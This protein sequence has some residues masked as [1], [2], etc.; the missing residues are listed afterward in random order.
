MKKFVTVGLVMSC[1]L[2]PASVYAAAAGSTALTES[3]GAADNTAAAF[4]LE[5]SATEVRRGGGIAISGTA[6][7]GMQDVVLKI[8]SPNQTV[9]YV[10]V[11]T[12]A[13]GSYSVN[14]AIPTSEELAPLGTYTVVAGSGGVQA[15]K[16][17]AVAGDGNNPGNGG[18]D[19]DNGG[20]NPGN[21]GNDPDNGGGNPGNGGGSGGGSGS[22]GGGGGTVV[23]PPK[24]TGI[25]SGAGQA[26]AAVIQPEQGQN[27]SYIVGA[28]T[29]AE[30]AGQAKDAVTIQ[31]PATAGESGAPLE[32]P[33][34]ALKDLQSKR[35]DLIITSG[36]HTV[37]F[38]AGSIGVSSTK[39][40]SILRFV[41]NTVMTEEAG[42]V[43]EEALQTNADYAATGVVLSV[44][45]QLITDGQVVEIH[46]LDKPASVSIRLTAE[47]AAKLRAS[48]ADV[49]Y[50][51][52]KQLQHIGGKLNGDVLT[53]TAKHFSYYAVLEYSK[54]FVDLAG[55]WAEQAVMQ[56]AAKQIV[57]GVDERHYE[58]NRAIT[59][60]EFV[61]LI[62]RSIEL[63]GSASGNTDKN[64]FTDVAAGQYYTGTIAAAAE[65]GIVTGYD[66]KFRPADRITREEAV[67]SLVRA[68]KYF[69]LSGKQQGE[70]SFADAGKISS[71]AAAAV[72]EAWSAGLI[73]G[74]GKA[75]KPQNPVTRAE[76]AVM[77]QRLLGDSL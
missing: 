5:L 12:A 55:H 17:F 57:N 58:P 6:P 38:P 3:A 67:V 19:P 68:A 22:S 20:G 43:I 47:Q 40:Q 4:T 27:G 69:S 61:T 51:D 18:N 1:L 70:A 2:S 33:A 44:V 64:P 39:E 74:D 36:N 13:E 46:E 30:A 50:V 53:F 56:L 11:I 16:T 24:Q 45:I 8:V 28:G 59:R 35:L 65:L 7:A 54:T 37:R 49:Y 9:F 42:K 73:E 76:V 15:S 25:S 72:K 62:M 21:G 10:D 32:F 63:T 34:G 71:W 48:L 66:G 75:F 26:A 77:I 23:T 52:G 41:L 31:L 60:A 29:M 14:V